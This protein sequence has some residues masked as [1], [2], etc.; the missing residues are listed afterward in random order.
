MIRRLTT[1]ENAY[2]NQLSERQLHIGKQIMRFMFMPV[3]ELKNGMHETG[4]PN[5]VMY[6][7]LVEAA[8]WTQTEM[9]E[10]LS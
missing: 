1:S 8:G 7:L 4:V 2:V 3:E 10:A 9:E 5:Y 6:V